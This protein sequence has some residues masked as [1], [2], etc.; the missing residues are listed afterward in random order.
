MSEH[1]FTLTPQ[2]ELEWGKMGIDVSH[3]KMQGIHLNDLMTDEGLF[4]NRSMTVRLQALAAQR[5]QHAREGVRECEDLNHERDDLRMLVV[6]RE[7]E[8]V[9]SLYG[10]NEERARAIARANIDGIGLD[11]DYV[12]VDP[13][14]SIY[15]PVCL[16]G[17]DYV[18]DTKLVG[19]HRLSF[20]QPTYMLD[21]TASVIM[22]LEVTKPHEHFLPGHIVTLA[23]NP[24]SWRTNTAVCQV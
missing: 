5:A 7:A 15:A 9:E 21:G 19:V 22:C 1:V 4:L 17:S 11:P 3:F 10:H 16:D 2:I 20:E 6:Q 12:A 13:R 14:Q 24:T 18:F 8:R 23:R